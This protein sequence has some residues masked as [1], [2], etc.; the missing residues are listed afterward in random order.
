M[1]NDALKPKHRHKLQEC[2]YQ[3]RTLVNAE[4][5]YFSLLVLQSDKMDVNC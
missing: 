1:M 5:S 2:Q 3:Q 4:S